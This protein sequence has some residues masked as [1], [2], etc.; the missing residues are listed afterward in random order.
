MLKE[1]GGKASCLQFKTEF[2]HVAA[3]ANIG[4]H[5]LQQKAIWWTSVRQLFNIL[6]QIFLMKRLEKFQKK[7]IFATYGPNNKMFMLFLDKIRHVPWK[8]PTILMI[9]TKNH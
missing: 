9:H 6:M 3:L 4:G 5:F 2:I 1:A 7:T 8:C